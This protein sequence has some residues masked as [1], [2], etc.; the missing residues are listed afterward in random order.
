MHE[1]RNEH[2]DITYESDPT[3]AA[4]DAAR[5]AAEKAFFEKHFGSGS[6]EQYLADMAHAAEVQEAVD[7]GR[8]TDLLRCYICHLEQTGKPDMTEHAIRSPL[9]G[10][11]RT[12]TINERQD[13]TAAYELIPC[14]HV[15]I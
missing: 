2:F 3:W 4:E 10:I 14:G 9:R 11:Q 7:E 12:R 6:Y 13:P 5:E 8:A 15:I 1:R